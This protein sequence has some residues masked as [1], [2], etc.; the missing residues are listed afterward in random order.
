ML[1]QKVFTLTLLL[2]S[3]TAQADAQKDRVVLTAETDTLEFIEKISQLP[4]ERLK[5]AVSGHTIAISATAKKKPRHDDLAIFGEVLTAGYIQFE[6]GPQGVLD[7]VR[8]DNFSGRLCPSYE[9]LRAALPFFSEIVKEGGEIILLNHPN[10][11][12]CS[13]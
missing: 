11:K 1:F 9:S 12:K 10:T 2:A 8:I 7:V 13:Q 6:F 5:F 3:L 4:K